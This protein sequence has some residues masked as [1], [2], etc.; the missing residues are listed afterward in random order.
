MAECVAENIS[1]NDGENVILRVSGDE[2]VW[3]NAE[4][5]VNECMRENVDVPVGDVNECMRENVSDHERDNFGECDAVS[6]GKNFDQHYHCQSSTSSNI[7]SIFGDNFKFGEAS[8]KDMSLFKFTKAKTK[9]RPKGHGVTFPKKRKAGQTKLSL[10]KSKACKKLKPIEVC[11][12]CGKE[13]I[14]KNLCEDGKYMEWVDCDN[15]E[16]WYHCQ[17]IGFKKAPKKYFCDLCA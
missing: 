1:E 6:V 7:V 12:K 2:C 5:D 8:S 14:E 9:G 11:G 3:V 16:K 13:E 17:C 4:D 10:T 15:C